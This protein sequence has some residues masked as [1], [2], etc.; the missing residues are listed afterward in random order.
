MIENNKGEKMIGKY[1]AVTGFFGTGS[2]AIIDLLK[3]YDGVNIASPVST[4]YE[5]MA[6]YS[7]GAFFDL[8]SK[9]LSPYRSVYG[10]DLA[11]NDFILAAKRLNNIDF[12]WYG[13]YK[14]HYGDLYMNSVNEFISSISEIK[15]GRTAAHCIGIRFSLVKA[16]LQIGAKILYK[17]PITVLGRKYI[18]DGLPSYY[19]MPT[20]AEFTNAAKEYI[21][22]Y[23]IMCSKKGDINIFDHLLWPQQ[24]NCIDDFFPD[25]FRLI[26]VIRDPRDVFLLN[27]NYWFK[28]P[29]ASPKSK[30]YF[31]TESSKFCEEW[32]R[33]M[34]EQITSKKVL[35]VQFED[36]IYQY[37][38]T[39][40][41]IE[42]FLE[43]NS[44]DHIKKFKYFNP[45]KSIENTQIHLLMDDWKKEV[46]P[47][48]EKLNNYIYKYPYERVPN[49]NLWFD[50]ELQLDAV[51]K[52]SKKTTNKE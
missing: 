2:S 23:L 40:T 11:I 1:V 7:N 36:L 13:G 14:K 12:G 5:H 6:L 52:K 48:Y 31:P 15:P 4:D 39:K 50:T 44:K 22:K 18:Y 21:S 33:I 17:R 8:A 16:L 49:K 30:P 9:L 38:S 25:N 45:Q 27:K 37:D 26:I 41:R 24:A 34:P 20:K 47:L 3:E 10:S 35:L 42:D 28:P 19:S 32:L 51:N 46:Q 29:V 43:I